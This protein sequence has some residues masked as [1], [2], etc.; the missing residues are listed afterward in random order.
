MAHHDSDSPI[1]ATLDL[2]GG[3][4]KGVLLFHL[5]DGTK[6]FNELKRL[7]PHVTHRIMTLQL[8]ELERAG[9]IHRQIHPEVPPKVE[10]SL[11]ELGRSLEPVLLAMKTWG[12][13]YLGDC[14]LR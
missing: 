7:V 10:Y 12:E 9:I 6:R 14:S 4:W 1:E 11:T 8:R 13:S 2:I 3:R 5:L